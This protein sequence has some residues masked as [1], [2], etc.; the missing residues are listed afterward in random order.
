MKIA[1]VDYSYNYLLI[2]G[3]S[4]G[5]RGIVELEVLKHIEMAL[6]GLPIQCFFDLIVGTR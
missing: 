1:R 4:G 3:S 2:H 6:G 5:I